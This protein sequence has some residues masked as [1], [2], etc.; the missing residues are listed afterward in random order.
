MERKNKPSSFNKLKKYFELREKYINLFATLEQHAVPNDVKNY[1]YSFAK[2][3]KNMGIDIEIYNDFDADIK[4]IAKDMKITLTKDAYH[5]LNYILVLMI[6]DITRKA[7]IITEHR[8][9]KRLASL[10]IEHAMEL[11]LM[12]N[13]KLQKA[14]LENGA[15]IYD[16]VQAQGKKTKII[17]ELYFNPEHV[18]K[19]MRDYF[20]PIDEKIRKANKKYSWDMEDVQIEAFAPIYLAAVIDIFITTI[21]KSLKNNANADDILQAMEENEEIRTMLLELY[22]DEP[23]AGYK[24]SGRQSPADIIRY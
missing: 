13:S 9:A 4:E 3:L 21:L 15:F 20:K 14:M 1:I 5:L 17:K 22:L 2:E 19:Y 12:K 6:K 24:P 23:L 10:D 18:K 11:Y 7:F 8:R 16:T